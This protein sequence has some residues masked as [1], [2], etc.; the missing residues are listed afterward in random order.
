MFN[1]QSDTERSRLLYSGV[2][3]LVKAKSEQFCNATRQRFDQW[4][5]LQ[6]RPQRIQKR[7]KVLPSNQ[8][9]M[10]FGQKLQNIEGPDP[11][12]ERVRSDYQG[13]KETAGER[14]EKEQTR[15][16]KG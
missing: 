15:K 4:L 7:R 3:L 12:W 5:H 2:I 8:I 1:Q 6:L 16:G 14:K 13:F 10:Q 9:K 11:M